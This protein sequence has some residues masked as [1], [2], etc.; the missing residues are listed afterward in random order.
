MIAVSIDF[1]F[2][3]SIVHQVKTAESR[4]SRHVA[5]LCGKY[6]LLYACKQPSSMDPNV[7]SQIQ[8]FCP[9]SALSQVLQGAPYGWPDCCVWAL[10]EAGETVSKLFPDTGPCPV[11]EKTGWHPGPAELV[12]PSTRPFQHATRLK[13]VMLLRHNVCARPNG[14]GPFHVNIPLS[15]IPM[16]KM[17]SR[18]MERLR[19]SVVGT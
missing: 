8:Q 2:A 13:D 5:N 6:F 12:M 19:R 16:D 4:N 11:H 7:L 17:D 14:S 1:W 18:Q 9:P 10:V 15:A 3:V